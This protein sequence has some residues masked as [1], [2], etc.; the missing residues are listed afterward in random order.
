MVDHLNAIQLPVKALANADG[1]GL[2]VG[3]NGEVFD[4]T[5][6][7][8]YLTCATPGTLTVADGQALTRTVLEHFATGNARLYIAQ[9]DENAWRALTGFVAYFDA[10]ITQP[11][12]AA[13]AA[14]VPL[15]VVSIYNRAIGIFN[16]A[17]VWVKPW[18]IQ[19]YAFAWVSGQSVPLCRRIRSVET[20]AMVLEADNEVHPLRAKQFSREVGFGV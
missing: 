12:T 11:I 20:D 7:N 2:P 9:G 3:P 10:R 8:H 6:H 14:G 1:A 18:M 16:G 4:G 13:Q 19:G 17:E 5:T 15:N